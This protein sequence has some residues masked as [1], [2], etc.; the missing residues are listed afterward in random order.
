MK[1]TYL[2]IAFC[3]IFLR[4]MSISQAQS[5]FI[6][7]KFYDKQENNVMAG[8]TLLSDNQIIATGTSKKLKIELQLGKE[9][10]LIISKEGFVSKTIN[11]STKTK[12]PNDYKFLFDV[13]LN[14]SLKTNHSSETNNNEAIAVFY[15]NEIRNFNYSQPNKNKTSY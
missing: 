4:L 12:I 10:T 14:K 13:I 2:K 1:T 15:D 11:F 9:Y 8:Y 3:I 7:G 6:D 5:L